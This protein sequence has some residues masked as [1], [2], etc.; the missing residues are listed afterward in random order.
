MILYFTGTGNSQMVAEIIGEEIGESTANVTDIIRD[1]A[2]D[3]NLTPGETLGF[4]LPTYYFGIPIHIREFL[5]KLRISCKPGYIWTCLTCESMTGAAGKMLADA[6]TEAGLPTDAQ[7][8]CPV[9]NNTLVMSDRQ[10]VPRV[11]PLVARAES[12]SRSIAHKVGLRR[13]GDFDD[14]KGFGARLITEQNYKYYQY[15]RNTRKFWCDD[16]C[17]ACGK[18]AAGCP[19]G[20]ITVVDGKAQWTAPKCYYCLRCINCC[21]QNAIH[22]GKADNTVTYVNPRIKGGL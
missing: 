17:I 1:G 2:Y 16:N 20:A 22:Y 10:A 3:I 5:L 4:V 14:C 8:G 11:E 18:C 9:V 12:L 15:G 6:M 21:P 13:R 19:A 7:F